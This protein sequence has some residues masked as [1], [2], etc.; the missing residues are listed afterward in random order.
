VFLGAVWGC[1][2]PKELRRHILSRHPD[3]VNNKDCF[4]QDCESFS[5]I[6]MKSG[7]FLSGAKARRKVKITHKYKI[8]YYFTG[9]VVA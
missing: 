1:I 6:R 5:V 7:I 3:K 2:L 8:Q 4:N 9:S